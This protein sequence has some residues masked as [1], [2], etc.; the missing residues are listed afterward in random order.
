MITKAGVPS[1][2]VIVGVTSYGRSFQ[3]VDPSCTGPDCLFTGGAGATGSGART[4]W[5]APYFLFSI[6]SL[7]PELFLI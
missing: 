4:Y 7:H 3:M 2:K 5:G 6:V 1:N